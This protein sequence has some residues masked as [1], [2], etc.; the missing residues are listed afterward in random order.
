MFG[1]KYN[2][3]RLAAYKSASSSPLLMALEFIVSGEIKKNKSIE[4]EFLLNLSR[5]LNWKPNADLNKIKQ[6][7][8]AVV[9]TDIDKNIVWV[10]GYFE[11]MTGY[12][13]D[14]VL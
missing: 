12:S 3:M 1:E 5:H 7:Y 10:N 4:L 13:K 6:A 11:T 2:E 9:V 8:M 14:E